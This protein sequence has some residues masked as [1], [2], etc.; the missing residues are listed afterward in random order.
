MAYTLCMRACRPLWRWLSSSQ[1]PSDSISSPRGLYPCLMLVSPVQCDFFSI[2]PTR[3]P[4]LLPS[5]A[6][7]RPRGLCL[8]SG[9]TESAERAAIPLPRPFG[10]CWFPP[11]LRTQW[12]EEGA[13]GVE[14]GASPQ[15]GHTGLWVR[16][17]LAAGYCRLCAVNRELK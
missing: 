8:R 10:T 11:H 6:A 16:P 1:I 7:A 2:Q 17:G 14:A 13:F 15:L 12:K 5:P 3:S 4:C 9:Q